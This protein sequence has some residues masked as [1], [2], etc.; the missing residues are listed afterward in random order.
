MTE[1]GKYVISEI[2]PELTKYLI[3]KGLSPKAD[4]KINDKDSI[5]FSNVKSDEI[6]MQSIGIPYSG[7][8]REEEADTVVK[9]LNEGINRIPQNEINKLKQMAENRFANRKLND[10]KVAEMIIDRT[11]PGLG[12]RI[13]AA[14]DIVSID[15]LKTSTD[16]KDEAWDNVIDF[17]K[18]YNEGVHE[19]NP[20]AYTTAELTD[21]STIFPA[22]NNAKY[23]GDADAERKFLEQ[24]G[25]ISVANYSYFFTL[26]TDM[27]SNYLADSNQPS[28]MSD[29]G[30]N[31]ELLKKLDTGWGNNPGFLFQS[32]D[33]GVTNSYTF[34]DNHDKPRLLHMLGVD[35][36]L[37]NTTF[38]KRGYEKD[39]DNE[40]ELQ[41][42]KDAA[43]VLEKEIEEVNEHDSGASVAMG[44]RID[45]AIESLESAKEL[46]QSLGSELKQSVKNLANG[47]YLGNEIED[48]SAFGKKPFDA[49]IGCVVKE[50]NHNR[51]SNNKLDEQEVKN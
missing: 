48:N 33:D 12:W 9:I 5:D 35:M 8:T 34:G 29:Q 10:F 22:D 31:F 40:I 38:E 37:F 36:N 51:P 6:T 30:K 32:P 16:E 13:D 43:Y 23:I 7:Y 2:A 17:W 1:Y 46:S 24:T 42:Y 21:L 26:M 20:H 3:I 4:I 39:P 19:Y 41:K 45:K 15:S 28:W 50:L 49:A 47:T 11:E 27:F 18:R 25:I 14:K 44:L